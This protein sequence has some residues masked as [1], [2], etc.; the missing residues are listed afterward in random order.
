MT[1]PLLHLDQARFRFRTLEEARALARFLAPYFPD[2]QAAEYGLNELLVNAIEHGN[3]GIDFAEKTA[4][5]RA[6]RWQEEIERRLAD[7][8]QQARFVTLCF[9]ASGSAIE[10]VIEDSGAGFD[11]RDYLEMTP[12]RALTP[13]GR[14]IA[15]ARRLAFDRLDYEGP[16]NR[17]RGRVER[18]VAS[19]SPLKESAFRSALLPE[20]ELQEAIMLQSLLL[21]PESR[22]AELRAAQGLDL[23]CYYQPSAGL[24]GDY[25]SVLPLSPTRTALILADLSGHGVTAALYAFALHALLEDR[26]LYTQEPGEILTHVNARLHPLLLE[27][28]F[29]TLFLGVVDTERNEIRYAAAAAPPPLLMDSGGRVTPLETRG[30]PLG[31]LREASYET[32]VAP[33]RRG[34]SLFCYSDALTETPSAAEEYFEEPRL[35]EFLTTQRDAEA[36]TLLRATLSHFFT[37][38]STLPADDLS[39][40]ACRRE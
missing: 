25:L 27:G 31:A 8:L 15:T 28:K 19:A 22:L 35:S 4:L 32:R 6:D 1:Q 3:L 34:D 23:A 2:A 7:P 9:E 11:W 36:N 26:G 18:Q 39:L 10:V 40:L 20:E 13:N 5:V 38:Y 30:F 17:V 12:E 16:G 33:F 37:H 14:G 24:G 21:P 29:A